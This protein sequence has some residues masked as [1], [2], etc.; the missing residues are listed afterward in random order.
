MLEKSEVDA[1]IELI[2][3]GGPSVVS[4]NQS[5]A[6][7]EYFMQ[8]PWVMTCSD[9]QITEFGKAIPHPRNYGTFPRKIRRYVLEKKVISMEQAVRSASGL[10]AEMLE[11][12]DRGLLKESYAADIAV[13]DSERIRDRATFEKPHQYSEGM[14]FVLVN[15][16]VVIRDGEFTGVLAGKPLTPAEP[17]N[18]VE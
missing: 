13:F 10:P 3:M 12:K 16:Q 17:A 7:V 18:S 9:G 8:K 6:D 1:A 4:F 11:F 14:D 15:G 2:F 5:D